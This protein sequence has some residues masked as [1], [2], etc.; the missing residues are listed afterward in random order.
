MINVLDGEG[1]DG[2]CVG[3]ERG[4]KGKGGFVGGSDSW[5]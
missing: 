4:I 3:W 1:V 2:N 5:H